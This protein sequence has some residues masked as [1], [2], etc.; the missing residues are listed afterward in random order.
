MFDGGSVILKEVEQDG[1]Q[2]NVLRGNVQEIIQWVDYKNWNDSGT[3]GKKKGLDVG[4]AGKRC[5]T[6]MEVRGI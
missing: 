2:K 1:C 5:I 6:E 4:Q 3:V